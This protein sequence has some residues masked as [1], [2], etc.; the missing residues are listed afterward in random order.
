MDISRVWLWLSFSIDLTKW[1]S[2]YP[3]PVSESCPLFSFW[4][5][6]SFVISHLGVRTHWQEEGRGR[7]LFIF[8]LVNSPGVRKP[9]VLFIINTIYLCRKGL[10]KMKAF[11]PNWT[12][13]EPCVVQYFYEPTS[14]Y[15]D[16][17]CFHFLVFGC[18][19]L[20]V[21]RL[22]WLSIHSRLASRDF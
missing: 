12:T 3:F 7:D 19:T 22:L 2:S 16:N 4:F 5:L 9:S 11:S 14:F 20:S 13:M 15:D 18:W 1:Q 10:Y 8:I 17:P 6:I 21:G